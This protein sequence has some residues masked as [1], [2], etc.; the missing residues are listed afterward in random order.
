M[1]IAVIGLYYAPN[2][3][4]AVICDCVAAWMREAYPSAQVDVID[5]ENSRAFPVHKQ[6]SALTRLRRKWNLRRDQWLTK[7]GIDDRI[8]YWNQIDVASRA[9][10]YDEVTGRGYAA[11]I[12]AGG[13]LF[14]DWLALDLCEF[15]KR[16]SEKSTPV[17]FN[18]CGTG[19]S[20]SKKIE[21]CLAVQMKNSNIKLVSSRDNCVEIE[22]RYFSGKKCVEQTYDPGL[23][24]KD[25]YC[26]RKEKSTTVG[27]GIMY[28]RNIGERCLVRFWKAVIRSLD[29]RG[30]AWK[31]FCNGDGD[32]YEYGCHV[33]KKLGYEPKK[34][35][36]DRPVSP[37]ELVRQISEFRSI[38]SF[39]LHSHV[40]AA[41][42]G[43]PGVAVV[44]D[45]KLSFFYKHL[46][47]P[48][49]CITVKT[50]GKPAADILMNAEREGI[51][52]KMIEH[53]KTA[54]RAILLDAVSQVIAV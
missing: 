49:R 3:G 51:D 5:I 12:F 30:V 32:D 15:L 10:F 47:H 21:N 26:I 28:D 40:V 29:R 44:W 13:Q 20:F 2:L 8:Y 25:T 19:S 16:F 53:Q 48:E 43:I 27:L 1:K 46:G 9:S 23:W 33:L 54:A 41:S 7:T 22:K 35:M 18:A 34:C 45:D 42:L 36:T 24:A 50:G 4:D 52:K 38:I 31:M 14:M 6:I 11:V 17:F 37:E 39:R